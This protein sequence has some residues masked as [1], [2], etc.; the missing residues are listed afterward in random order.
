[1][2]WWK[3]G[4]ESRVYI[5]C[6]GGIFYSNDGGASWVDKN[7]NLGLK[8]F[9]ACAIHPA[10]GSNYLLAGAQ[11]NGCHQLKNPG[12]SYSTEVTGGDGMYVYINQLDPSIQ[13]GSYTNNQYRRSVNGGQTWSSVN[14]STQGLFAN[15]FDY[16]DAQNIM[17]SAN[18]GNQYRRWLNANTAAANTSTVL[19]VT[20]LNGGSAGAVRMSPYT[21][22]RIYL[23]GTSGKV[24]KVDA[25]D[26]ATPVPTDITG[27]SFPAGYINCVNVGSSDNFLVATFTNYGVN[28]VWY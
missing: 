24:V 16:D 12:L 3:K 23:G 10:A 28:N 22:N 19:T 5:G 20:Q 14:L 15:P 18:A 7:R 6:D 11:D 17:Y 26:G 9:Y 27:A 8:Q 1:M 4:N 2:Q 21:A 13:F 25:A